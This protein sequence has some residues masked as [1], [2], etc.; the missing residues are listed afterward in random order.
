MAA[1]PVGR[2]RLRQVVPSTIWLESLLTY[3]RNKCDLQRPLCN[4]CCS[5]GH[6]CGGYGRDRTFTPVSSGDQC[7]EGSS[8]STSLEKTRNRQSRKATTRNSIE[9]TAL[10]RS[11]PHMLPT[12]LLQSPAAGSA[13]SEQFLALY[14]RLYLPR[15]PKELSAGRFTSVL[16]VLPNMLGTSDALDNASRAL[17]MLGVGNQRGDGRLV[18]ESIAVYGRAMKELRNELLHPSW[19]NQYTTLATTS[20]LAMYEVLS[21]YLHLEILISTKIIKQGT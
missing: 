1:I 14:T 5:N 9:S 11:P 6:I 4:R 10:L 12:S 3:T 15:V 2:G 18:N 17:S 13:Y 8:P 19:K 16:Q 20:V 7:F 21:P